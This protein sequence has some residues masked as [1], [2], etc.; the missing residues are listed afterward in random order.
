[1]NSNV[2]MGFMPEM[3]NQGNAQNITFCVTQDCNMRCKYCYMDGK[4]SYKRMSL[5]TAKNAVDYFLSSPISSEAVI[6]EFIGGEPLLEIELI[7]KT[8]DYIK[9]KMYE[10]NHPWLN[11]YMISIGTNGLLYNTFEVQHFIKKNRTHLSIGIT[12]DGTK[13]KHDLNR[14]KIDGSGT[15]NDI[16]GNVKLWL[17][18]FPNAATK[19]TFSSEDLIYLKDSIIHLWSLG[20]KMIPANIVFENVWKEGD[21]KIYENQLKQLADYII[22]NNLW[23]DY[24]VRFFDPYSGFP[25]SKREKERNYCGVGKMIA[26]DSEGSLYPCIRFIDFCLLGKPSLSTGNIYDGNNNIIEAFK[27][28]DRG[29]I[30]DGECSEC[31]ISSGCFSC[32]GCNYEFSSTNSIFIRTKFHC[33]MYK[34]QIRANEYFWDKLSGLIQEITP[35]ELIRMQTYKQANWDLDGAKYLFF[36]IHNN[37]IPHCMY[38]T[39]DLNYEMK[40]DV[41]KEGLKYAHDNNMI[42]VFLGDPGDLLCRKEANKVHILISNEKGYVARNE[43]EEVIPVIDTHDFYEPSFAESCILLIY[44]DNI[45]RLKE[46]VDQLYRSERCRRINIIKKDLFNWDDTDLNEYDCVLQDLYSWSQNSS[47]SINIFDYLEERTF[48]DAGRNEFT[49]APNGNFYICPGY[50]FNDKNNTIGNLSTG[51]RVLDQELFEIQKSKKCL[52]CDAKQCIRCSFI[53]Y[54]K[55]KMINV[56]ASIQCNV[57]ELENQFLGKR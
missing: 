53:N 49:L 25:L 47:I 2:K 21:E 40:E 10:L 13:E 33:K 56:P 7:D 51:I 15:Y 34:A 27:N 17:K 26:V 44:K 42:P 14:I 35:H 9:K 54:K 48:C 52:Q 18:Q 23:Q 37:M 3:Y 28:L 38:D 32:T 24:S 4:N 16:I 30:N 46:Y 19:V 5:D 50:Y 20:L 36:I 8:V 12:I 45:V 31:P 39:D 6:W 43:V 55:T 41:F 11:K 57:S 1:M 29:V 22:D